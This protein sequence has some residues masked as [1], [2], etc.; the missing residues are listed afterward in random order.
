[1]QI[2]YFDADGFYTHSGELPT[3]PVTGKPFDHNP[4]VCTPDPLPQHDLETDRV[5]RL[6]G[7]WTVEPIPLPEPEPAKQTVEQE[8]ERARAAINP[9]RDTFLNRLAG[10]TVFTQDEAV[11]AECA[12]LRT[13]LLDI[14]KDPAF[15]A[16]ETEEAMT[17]AILQRY[18]EIAAT[19][20]E[21]I[22][23]VFRE[24]TQE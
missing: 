24:L 5:R 12:E 7:A 21:T 4:D 1:M 9:L 19:A 10:I 22:K 17:L 20:N 2:H 3:N 6:A 13:A 11:K 15:L 23:N 18:K 16:A 8:R 14:T